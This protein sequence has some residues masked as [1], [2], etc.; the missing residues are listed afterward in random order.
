M[1]NRKTYFIREHVGFMK[2]SDTYD[3]LD[4]DTQEQIGIAKEKPGA[5]IRPGFIGHRFGQLLDEAEIA[6]PEKGGPTLHSL[7]TGFLTLLAETG[8]SPDLTAP[9][10]GHVDGDVA[11]RWYIEQSAEAARSAWDQVAGRLTGET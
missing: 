10:A 5:P 6:V 7:R 8:V 11:R 1:L 3:I 2:L 4:P 9:V